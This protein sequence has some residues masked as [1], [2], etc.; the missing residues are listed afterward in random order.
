MF[1]IEP[2]ATRNKKPYQKKFAR[3]A[4]R[5]IFANQFSQCLLIKSQKVN[6]DS[7]KDIYD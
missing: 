3:L 6:F 4:A 2:S 7:K 5:A 1:L